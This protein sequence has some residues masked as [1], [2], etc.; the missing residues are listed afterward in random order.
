MVPNHWTRDVALE[1]QKHAPLDVES[2]QRIIAKHCP[3]KPGRAYAEVIPPKAGNV[4][5]WASNCAG[6]L[7]GCGYLKRDDD[8]AR[9]AAIVETFA[10]KLML[11]IGRTRKDHDVICPKSFED[12]DDE[13]CNCGADAWNAEID[14]ALKDATL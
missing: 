9:V 11:L 4:V 14:D 10:A 6:Y 3:F 7:A 8:V 5:D 2:V 1:L 13:P 12:G